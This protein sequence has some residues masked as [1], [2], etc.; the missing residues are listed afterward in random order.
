[1]ETYKSNIIKAMLLSMII[2]TFYG[3]TSSKSKI[4]ICGEWISKSA[5]GS[6]VVFNFLPNNIIETQEDSHKVMGHYEVDYGKNPMHL[7]LTW[8]DGDGYTTLAIFEFV[9]NNLMKIG[10]NNDDNNKRPVSFDN[11]NI[12]FYFTKKEN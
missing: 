8:S 4:N 9:G 3:C 2:V 12:T 7:N 5:T 1:M 6:E 11:S 10:Y